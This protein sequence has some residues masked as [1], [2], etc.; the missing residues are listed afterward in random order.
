MLVTDMTCITPMSR[1]AQYFQ[2][3]DAKHGFHGMSARRSMNERLLLAQ[4]NPVNR[5]LGTT[6]VIVDMTDMT[7]ITPMSW[8]ARCWWPWDAKHGFH[9]M[10]TR[11]S[12]NERLLLARLNPVNRCL[13]TTRVIVDVT[14][15]MSARC[16]RAGHNG[17]LALA[18][19]RT[20]GQAVDTC[21][22]NRACKKCHH[23]SHTRVPPD[24]PTYPCMWQSPRA[25]PI[26][27]PPCVPSYAQ[28]PILYL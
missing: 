24:T 17:G 3:W 8:H 27:G 22:D 15:M 12:M 14:D 4:L 7:C 10:S 19:G 16:H 25:M 1:H 20:Y 6:R 21:E 2:L 13:G 18:N 26:I 5:C 23:L 9:G 11:L 28:R